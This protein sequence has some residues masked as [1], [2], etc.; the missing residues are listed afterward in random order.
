M[1]ICNTGEK[2][3]KMKCFFFSSYFNGR[4]TKTSA[5]GQNTIGC[6]YDLDLLMMGL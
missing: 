3:V 5:E 1:N 4:T 2:Y 6:M